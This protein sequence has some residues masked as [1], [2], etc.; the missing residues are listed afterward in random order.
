MTASR[1]MQSW[2]FFSTVAQ[3]VFASS[4]LFGDELHFIEML[5]I[6]YKQWQKFAPYTSFSLSF[7][8]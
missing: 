4:S 5:N 6:L 3:N 8:C 1:V 2:Q 7:K